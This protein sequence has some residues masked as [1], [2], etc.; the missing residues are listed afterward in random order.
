MDAPA[1]SLELRWSGIHAVWSG[2]GE[3]SVT[4]TRFPLPARATV[5][6]ERSKI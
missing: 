4:E 5:G 2:A 6:R 3:A 1:M